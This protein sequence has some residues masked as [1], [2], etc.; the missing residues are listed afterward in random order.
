VYRIDVRPFV[1]GRHFDG[2]LADLEA[3]A[4]MLSRCHEVLSRFPRWADVR[5]AAALRNDRLAWIRDRLAASLMSHGPKAVAEYAEWAADNREWLAEMIDGFDPHIERWPSAQC[6]HG[7]VH[8]GNVMFRESDGAAVLLDLEEAVHFFAP[9]AWDI[10]F[11]IQRFALA[12][13]PSPATLQARISR[14]TAGYGAPLPALAPVMRQA[15]WFA[16][17][18]ILDLRMMKGTVVPLAEVEKFV[19]LERQ[20]AAYAGMV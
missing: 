7:E 9:P 20:A 13:N 19:T 6:L 18:V 8:Q 15:A 11:L 3:L 12:D 1:D 5:A 16:M 4:R 14:I 2:S 10:A 17:T